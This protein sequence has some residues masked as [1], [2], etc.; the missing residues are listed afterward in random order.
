MLNVFEPC[1]LQLGDKSFYKLKDTDRIMKKEEWN[2]VQATVFPRKLSKN[3]DVKSEIPLHKDPASI[4]SSN[5]DNNKL[6]FCIFFSF[7]FV[8]ILPSEILA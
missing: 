4:N 7:K 5:Q 2:R 1:T 6:D 3:I 8:S